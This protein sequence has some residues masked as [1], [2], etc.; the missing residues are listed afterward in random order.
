MTEIADA[1]MNV[2]SIFRQN[3]RRIENTSI[4]IRDHRDVE[5]TREPVLQHFEWMQKIQDH[6]Q[7]RSPKQVEVSILDK[8]SMGIAIRK[9]LPAKCD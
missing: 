2:T 7:G 8:E 4:C 5:Y 3:Q 9:I 1:E 6:T